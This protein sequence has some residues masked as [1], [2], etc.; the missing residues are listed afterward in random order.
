MFKKILVLLGL[1]ALSFSYTE[2]GNL[3]KLTGEDFAKAL[4]EFP[5]MLVKFFAPWYCLYNSGVD[6]VRN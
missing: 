3:L 4:E 6:I 1:I 2:E 5:H